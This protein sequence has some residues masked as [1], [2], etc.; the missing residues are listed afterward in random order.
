MIHDLANLEPVLRQYHPEKVLVGPLLSLWTNSSF[1]VFKIAG[2]GG[3]IYETIGLGFVKVETDAQRRRADIVAVLQSRFGEVQI[4]DRQ[5]EMA[6]VAHT[7]WANDETSRF[8]ATATAESKLRPTRKVDQDQSMDDAGKSSVLLSD[9]D[10]QLIDEA[11]RG[12]PSAHAPLSTAGQ[13]QPT[14]AR[15]PTRT[16]E[17]LDL[18]KVHASLPR[19][20]DSLTFAV[21][22]LESSTEPGASTETVAETVANTQTAA[23]TDADTE[24]AAETGANTETIAE[25]DANTFDTRSA[26][27]KRPSRRRRRGSPAGAGGAA[28]AAAVANTEAIAETDSNTETAT[29]TAANTRVVF[30]HSDQIPV[31]KQLQNQLVSSGASACSEDHALRQRSP[32]RDLVLLPTPP[33]P[34]LKWPSVERIIAICIV[35]LAVASVIVLRIDYEHS[36]D[37]N[38][39]SPSA[40]LYSGSAS[41]SVE[42]TGASAVAVDLYSRC[43]NSQ[44]ID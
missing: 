3:K 20:R 2:N 12:S 44:M 28:P 26:K 40:S 9:R 43:S 29:E 32:G 23:E 34:D 25:T 5:L 18:S 16:H 24:T 11:A 17:P 27:S 31:E 38:I 42:F 36:I 35:I 7:L 21:V 6:R 22:G 4:F 19:D 33:A 15:D 8:L 39:P 10:K 1:R 41:A 37:D 14:P 30:E 13:A